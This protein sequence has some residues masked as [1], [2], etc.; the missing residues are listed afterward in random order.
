MPRPAK[1]PIL[2]PRQPKTP[3]AWAMQKQRIVH[4]W[5]GKQVAEAY[6]C[7]PGRISRVE[8]GDS[9]PT[10]PLVLFY[11][12][13]FNCDGLLMS[14]YEIVVTAAE[15]QVRRSR[16]RKRP[17]SFAIPG[18]ASTFLGD[19]VPHGTLMKPGELFLKAWT[20]KNSGSIPWIDRSLE[21]QG[22]LTGPMRTYFRAKYDL[23]PEQA[24]R[25]EQYINRYVDGDRRAA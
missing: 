9:P 5:T 14:Q 20:I 21:R 22:P 8:L 10:R 2:R 6:G 11:E 24:E 15:Q 3:L 12:D 18:D 7:S 17:V 19:T 25:I 16:G 4:G 1:L 23:T 13:V